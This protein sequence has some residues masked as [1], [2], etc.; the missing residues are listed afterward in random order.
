MLPLPLASAMPNARMGRLWT[1]ENSHG[2]IMECI[3]R[4]PVFLDLTL[5]LPVLRMLRM[6]L[7]RGPWRINSHI[8]CL[9]SG[10]FFHN[11]YL[12]A[13]FLV[14]VMITKRMVNG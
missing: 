7:R 11:E 1:R 2:S 14:V 13:F 8:D 9:N 10:V 6:I 3:S 4:Q 12:G 5:L